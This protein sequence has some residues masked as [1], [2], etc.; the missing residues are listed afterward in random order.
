MALKTALVGIGKIARDQHIPA[1]EANVEFE[2]VA[3]ASRNAEVEGI[4]AFR[5]L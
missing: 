2:L 4:P 3:T 1:I 5:D